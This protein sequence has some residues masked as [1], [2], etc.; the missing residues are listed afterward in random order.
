[1]LPLMVIGYLSL[2]GLSTKIMIPPAKVPKIGVSWGPL[3]GNND[4]IDSLNDSLR[5]AD[6][7]IASL[8]NRKVTSHCG[9]EVDSSDF[10]SESLDDDIKYGDWISEKF[11]VIVRKHYF[12]ERNRLG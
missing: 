3:V 4:E 2:Q 5:R 6:D 8:V 9:N 11:V 7:D 1:M 12:D 10:I